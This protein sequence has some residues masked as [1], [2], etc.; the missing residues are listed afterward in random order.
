MK[1][2]AAILVESN[3]DLIV[4]EI[5]INNALKEGQVL[6]QIEQSGICGAQINEIDAVKGVDVFLPHLLGHEG[7][8]K[9]LEIGRSVKNINVGD[10]VVLH[11]R[12][13]IGIQ[14]ET[15]KYSWMDKVLNSGWVT[16]FSELTV[17]SE[18][19]LT[20]ISKTVMSEHLPLLGCGLTTVFGSLESEVSIKLGDSVLILGIGAIGSLALIASKLKGAGNITALDNRQ[21]KSN[22]AKACGADLFYT[23]N[24]S[25]LNDPSAEGFIGNELYDLI[26]DTTGDSS[27]ISKSFEKLHKNGT[28]L[29]IG[30]MP[31]SQ[32]LSINSLGLN[33]GKKILGTQGGSSKPEIDIPKLVLAIEKNILN[34]DV[35]PYKKRPLEQI[36]TSIQDIR[37]GLP[38]KQY[39][40]MH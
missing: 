3:Q 18:N 27:L 20:P 6:V 31:H 10:R 37:I 35:L 1:T 15:Y 11:W 7:I 23:V 33:L 13:G 34:L 8:G 21:N 14:S 4:D 17:V 38:F 9:V 25:T 29:I 2:L 30:V 12:P 39:I 19:R 22:L 28:L 24:T 5:G 16:T 26:I 40:T 32:K 36:N